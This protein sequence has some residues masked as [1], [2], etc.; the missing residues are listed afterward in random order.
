MMLV[1]GIT[2]K[3]SLMEQKSGA[4]RVGI[5]APRECRI[6]RN[7]IYQDVNEQNRASLDSNIPEISAKSS[8]SVSKL[9]RLTLK[10]K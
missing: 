2:V 5:D 10:K 9:N 1:N 3:I 4:V 8:P 6:V 7:E